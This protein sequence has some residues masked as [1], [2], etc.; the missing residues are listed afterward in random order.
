MSLSLYIYADSVLNP[1]A[2]KTGS[3]ANI[4]KFQTAFIRGNPWV[5]ALYPAR[6]AFNTRTVR[7][8]SRVK[9]CMELRDTVDRRERA[10]LHNADAVRG[11]FRVRGS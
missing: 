10:I 11:L 1:F 5:R 8:Q 2:H 4:P 9:E 7:L 6:A 3:P